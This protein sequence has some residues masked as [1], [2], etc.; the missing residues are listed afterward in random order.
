MVADRINA[1]KF[2][3]PGS[4]GKTGRGSRRE[5]RGTARRASL[6]PAADRS[7]REHASAGELLEKELHRRCSR[8]ELHHK[9]SVLYLK[10]QACV[11]VFKERNPT[12]H[13][14]LI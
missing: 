8:R 11:V 1:G 14:T 13:R 10:S 6:T 3:N 2:T 5:G 7:P 4:A 12:K 9:R